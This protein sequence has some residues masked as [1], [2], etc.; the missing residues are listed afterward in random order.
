VVLRPAARRRHVS[1][2]D[3]ARR[4]V[5]RAERQ[6]LERAEELRAQAE[7]LLKATSSQTVDAEA[8][9]KEQYEEQL[10]ALRGEMEQAG[11][12]ATAAECELELLR[13]SFADLR[14]RAK[15]AGLEVP[16]PTPRG[17]AVH[18]LAASAPSGEDSPLA[19]LLERMN[20]D[21]DRL[22]EA[23]NATVSRLRAQ[24]ELE[25]TRARQEA[26]SIVQAASQEAEDL[27]KTTLDAI[28]RDNA[29]ASAAREQAESDGAAAAALFAQAEAALAE[30]GAQ[31]GEVVASARAE[32]EHI[33]AAARTE[34][35]RILAE[36]HDRAFRDAQDIRRRLS[37]EIRAMRLAMDRTRDSLE[38]FLEATT[39]PETDP[40][41][42]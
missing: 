4:M 21:T 17:A 13:G 11:R 12:R 37:D 26:V 6:A 40:V 32:A 19:G 29:I 41:L 5:T 38:A 42:Q 14:A 23:A 22:M 28:D 15:E 3:H 18:V 31:A 7:A 25:L 36:A 8:R 16:E 39:P 27:L 10:R 35:E 34:A 30:A 20:L 2:L 33:V 1:D 9:V 24:A